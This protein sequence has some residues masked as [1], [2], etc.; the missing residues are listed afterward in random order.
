MT[1]GRWTEID[2]WARNLLAPIGMPSSE[3][4]PSGLPLASEKMFAVALDFSA[5]F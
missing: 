3:T 4:S 2:R 1:P 5:R